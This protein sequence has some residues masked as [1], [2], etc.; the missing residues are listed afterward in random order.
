MTSASHDCVSSAVSHEGAYSTRINLGQSTMVIE[1]TQQ[2]V[3][4]AV[5]RTRFRASLKNAHASALHNSGYSTYVGLGDAHIN[6][7]KCLGAL[8]EI[9]QQSSALVRYEY[10]S[11]RLVINDLGLKSAIIGASFSD[12]WPKITAVYSARNLHGEI[13]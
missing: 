2:E 9:P 3:H 11:A 13:E 4:L 12:Q 1:S 6:E 8:A 7:F 5:K 10:S